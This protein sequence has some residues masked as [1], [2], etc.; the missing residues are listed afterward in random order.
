VSWQECA[1]RRRQLPQ[2]SPSVAGAGAKGK[3]QNLAAPPQELFALF[4]SYSFDLKRHLRDGAQRDGA[5]QPK[6]FPREQA[7]GHCQNLAVFSSSSTC[8][9]RPLPP[10]FHPVRTALPAVHNIRAV[11]VDDKWILFTERQRA[12][13]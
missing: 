13:S 8:Q 12:N 1:G 7:R 5:Q 4:M 2:G 3:N 6:P 11:T 10:G 9:A